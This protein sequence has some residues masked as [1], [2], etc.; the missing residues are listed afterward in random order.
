MKDSFQRSVLEAKAEQFFKCGWLLEIF[1]GEYCLRNPRA[2]NMVYSKKFSAEDDFETPF[3]Y[4]ISK[5][6]KGALEILQF[7]ETHPDIVGKFH[8]IYPDNIIYRY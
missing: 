6:K 5:E 7:L 3:E 8:S 2:S 4:G 1:S